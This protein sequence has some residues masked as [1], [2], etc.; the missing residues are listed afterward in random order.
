LPA[1]GQEIALIA[2]QYPAQRNVTLRAMEPLGA[3][4]EGLGD[5]KTRRQGEGG[6]RRRG[7]GETNRLG[8]GETGRR[9]DGEI[10]KEIVLS[11]FPLVPP[12]PCLR[13]SGSLL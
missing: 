1:L 8:D 3:P 5:G 12:S 11:P 2:Q 9:G 13:R 6:T 10:G 7:Y 4:E